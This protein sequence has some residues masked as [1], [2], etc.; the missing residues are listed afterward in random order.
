MIAGPISFQDA[1]TAKAMYD[2]T[3]ST[4]DPE[5]RSW[6]VE[7]KY[8]RLHPE[9]RLVIEPTALFDQY[10]YKGSVSA[11]DLPNNR[12]GTLVDRDKYR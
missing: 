9:Q 11:R 6:S 2:Q 8:N 7:I 4:L 12:L 1:P 5:N 10:M 3:C